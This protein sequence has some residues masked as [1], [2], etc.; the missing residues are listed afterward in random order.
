[1]QKKTKAGGSSKVFR[2]IIDVFLI[3]CHLPISTDQWLKKLETNSFCF[4]PVF[5]FFLPG[6]QTLRS[7]DSHTSGTIFRILTSPFG[8]IRI[9]PELLP[10]CSV[11][12]LGELWEKGEISR[13]HFDK[14]RVM[15]LFFTIEGILC[16]TS[17]KWSNA[18]MM[19]LMMLHE[20]E[21]LRW[22]CSDRFIF[23][24]FQHDGGY[25]RTWPSF[26]IGVSHE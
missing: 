21:I 4:F 9:F 1:M 11:E 12:M 17:V 13:L 24:Y 6:I 8:W 23:V 18:R 10:P 5:A 22:E 20:R 3:I 16:P 19:I 2:S 15:Y 7:R 25:A 14:P 26:N